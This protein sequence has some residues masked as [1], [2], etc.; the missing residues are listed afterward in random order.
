LNARRLWHIVVGFYQLLGLPIMAVADQT[1]YGPRGVRFW[2]V[3]ADQASVVLVFTVLFELSVFFLARAVWLRDSV[4]KRLYL[5][6]F[7]LAFFPAL[8][9]VFRA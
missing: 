6:L 2:N 3:P 7:A 8:W 1:Y 9:L 5:V 4:R